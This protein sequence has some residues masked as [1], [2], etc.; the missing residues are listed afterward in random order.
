MLEQLDRLLRLLLLGPGGTP[1]P[2]GDPNT[3]LAWFLFLVQWAAIL[4]SAL[5]G[6]YAARRNGLGFFGSLVIAFVSCVGGG[7]V[8]DLLL[9]RIPV[10]W[11]QQA[12]YPVTVLLVTSAAAL[13]IGKAEHGEA[14]AD[15]I[16]EPV[17]RLVAHRSRAVILLDAL[18]LGLWTYLGAFYALEEGVAPI[19]APIMGVIGGSFGGVLRDVF[20]ARIPQQFKPGQL[21]VLGAAAGATAYVVLALLGYQALGFTACLALTFAVRM[22]T[23]RYTLLGPAQAAPEPQG[24]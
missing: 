18:A 22:L 4:L 3:A 1:S 8:R 2:G 15:V 10:F 5:T 11:L 17:E 24:S 23:I 13:V 14:L 6:L 9:G 21:Y 16:A 7:T 19:T 20:F 12:V